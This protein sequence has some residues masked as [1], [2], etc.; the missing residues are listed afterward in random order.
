[1]AD[2]RTTVHKSRKPLRITDG[3]TSF[4][5]LIRGPEDC[6]DLPAQV[7]I[8]CK[9][10]K[11]MTKLSPR[12]KY[13]FGESE[14]VD[15]APKWTIGKPPAYLGVKAQCQIC[16]KSQIVAAKTSIPTI[17]TNGLRDW[18]D[19]HAHLSNEQALEALEQR[20]ATSLR[21]AM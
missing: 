4:L 7:R 11:H 20:A 2:E 1:M 19:R 21:R 15:K 13:Q 14:Y 17:M 9:V 8:W 16:R 3:A 12:S 10:C 18:A 5:R 6:G